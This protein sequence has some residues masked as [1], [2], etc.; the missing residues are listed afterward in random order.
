MAIA[1]LAI[2]GFSNQI[3][4]QDY[5]LK[6]LKTIT[7]GLPPIGNARQAVLGNDGK[8]YIQNNSN[9]TIEVWDENGKT[10]LTNSGKAWSITSDDAGNIIV[11]GD[12][13]SA[14]GTQFSKLSNI[15]VYP[16]TGGEGVKISVSGLPAGRMD[17]LGHITGN[18]LNGTA[19]MYLPNTGTTEAIIIKFIKDASGSIKQEAP[20]K[21]TIDT[22]LASVADNLTIIDGTANGFIYRVRGAKS[23]IDVTLNDTKDKI[24]STTILNTPNVT[25]TVGGTVFNLGDTDFIAYNIGENYKDGFSIAKRTGNDKNDVIATHATTSGISANMNSYANWL[26]AQPKDANTM[27]IYQYLPGACI[28]IYEFSKNYPE[29]VYVAGT[30]NGWNAVE[31]E[32][33]TMTQPGI[34]EGLVTFAAEENGRGRFELSTMKADWDAGFNAHK[35]GSNSDGAYWFEETQKI[36]TVMGK[37]TGFSINNPGTYNVVVDLSNNYVALYPENVY[38]VG[39]LYEKE[40]NTAT[41]PALTYEGNGKYSLLETILMPNVEN[42]QNM[43]AGLAEFTFITNCSAEGDKNVWEKPNQRPRYGAEN[44]NI[45]LESGKAAKV[46]KKGG[47]ALNWK[48]ETGKYRLDLDL[49]NMT[50]VATYLNPTGVEESEA[51]A[52]ATV[53]GGEGFI[54][55]AGDAENVEVYTIAGALV[56]AGQKSVECAAGIYIVNVDGNATKVVVR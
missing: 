29:A 24:V 40:W 44:T 36:P 34:Y 9:S 51:V 45:E 48:I 12:G 49:N 5:S 43:N 19:T 17:L 38:I 31:A 53:I 35:I 8:I 52:A 37:N 4:A 25:T 32:T 10:T 15:I 20:T 56:S 27:K 6:E 1:V 7:A 26:F 11:P 41:A 54:E 55:V 14:W 3:S 21:V 33:L 13:S 47:D 46:A 2:L 50:V 22:K 28:K 42:G 30:N 18:I 23:F 16:A 39:S